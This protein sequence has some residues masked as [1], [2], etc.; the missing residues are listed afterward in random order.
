[1]GK[2]VETCCNP[3]EGAL[4]ANLRPAASKR[5]LGENSERTKTMRDREEGTHFDSGCQA[6]WDLFVVGIN[7]CSISLILRIGDHSVCC[8]ASTGLQA[9]VSMEKE[10]EHRYYTYSADFRDFKG[11]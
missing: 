5:S 6:K 2:S 3:V 8:I 11:V 7:S 10:H 4:H 1:M 9:V